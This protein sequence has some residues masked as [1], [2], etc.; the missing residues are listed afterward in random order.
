MLNLNKLLIATGLTL[1]LV[2]CASTP[3]TPRRATARASDSVPQQA[4]CVESGSRIA[5]DC[6]T[7]GRAYDNRDIKSTGQ[8]DA[9]S[10]M[11]MLDPSLTVTGH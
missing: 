7:T 9:A 10:A 3:S 6:A 5:D 8:T 1:C 4:G 11:R 2:A